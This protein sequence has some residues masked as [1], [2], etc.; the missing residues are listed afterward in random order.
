[1]TR[2][3]QFDGQAMSPAATGHRDYPLARCGITR[4]TLLH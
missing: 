2:P 3:D 4:Y 1:M